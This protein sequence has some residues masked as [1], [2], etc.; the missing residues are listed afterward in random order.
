[1]LK[2]GPGDYDQKVMPDKVSHLHVDS[3]SIGLSTRP[4]IA[5]TNLVPGPG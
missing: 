1:M 5:N 2:P 3:Q 4:P